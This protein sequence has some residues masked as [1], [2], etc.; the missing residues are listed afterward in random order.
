MDQIDVK[1]LSL[2]EKNAR[3]P[4]KQLA[5]SVYLSSPATAARI[6]KLEQDGVISGY[7]V[8]EY[9]QRAIKAEVSSYL[10]KPVPRVEL[11]AAVM[12]CIM[13][14]DA[15]RMGT[16]AERLGNADYVVDILVNGEIS[17]DGLLPFNM[18]TLAIVKY[19][20]PAVKCY[21]DKMHIF[22]K[23]NIISLRF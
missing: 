3:M 7:S 15:D 11:E 20:Q 10:L 5:E 8:F 2:L 14:I 21:E 17:A 19:A 13:R 18:Y 6:E 22:E 1:L 9:A 4:L 12:K 23:L 16:M